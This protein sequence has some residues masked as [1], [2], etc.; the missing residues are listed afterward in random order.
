MTEHNY[1]DEPEDMIDEP[2]NVLPD[3]TI[4]GIEELDRGV[5]EDTYENRMILRR[6][7]Y[8]VRTLFDNK[9]EPTGRIYAIDDDVRRNESLDSLE[10]KKT[11]LVN[12]RNRNSDFVQGEDLLL[13]T[14]ADSLVPSWVW[15]ATRR[16]I[17][18]DAERK[19]QGKVSKS[20]AGPP[21]RCKY[22]KADGARCQMWHA[23]TIKENATCRTHL[24]RTGDRAGT[25]EKNHVAHARNRLKYSTEKAVDVLVDLMEAADSEPVR[26]KAASEVL[27]RA[28][29]R[30]G[31]EIETTNTHEFLSPA[32]TIKARLAAMRQANADKLER[33]QRAAIEAA[34]EDANTVYVEVVEDNQ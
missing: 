18:E 10:L 5:C 4:L 24:N 22:I 11:I 27:D 14:D 34:Q 33:E 8:T 32:E 1:I 3:L 23:G 9:G 6:E 13:T 20:V 15:S 16:F 21:G 29:V 30:G 12:I 28:G 17:R 31:I 7:K 25:A 19:A 26:L 2:I